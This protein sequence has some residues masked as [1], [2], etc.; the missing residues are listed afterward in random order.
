MASWPQ[1]WYFSISIHILQLAPAI[2]EGKKKKSNKKNPT[3]FPKLACLMKIKI[4]I[5][6]SSALQPRPELMVLV[7]IRM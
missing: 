6:E 5:I 4:I 3:A 7:G 1:L 2:E